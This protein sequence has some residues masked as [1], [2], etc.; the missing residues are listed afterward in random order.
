MMQDTNRGTGRTTAQM[1]ALPQKGVFVS[2]NE[3]CVYYDKNLARKINR[4]DIQIVP[5]SWI[6]SERWQGCEYTAIE[7][8]HAYPDCNRNTM[9]FYDYLEHAKTRVRLP[10]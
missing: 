4:P 7:V 5:P 10:K 3:R 8:D 6:T 1:K 9:F 2:C